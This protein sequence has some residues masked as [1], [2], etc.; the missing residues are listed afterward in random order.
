EGCALF[1]QICHW[2][3]S[4]LVAL[5]STRTRRDSLTSRDNAMARLSFACITTSEARYSLP[6]A[7]RNEAQSNDHFVK[8]CGIRAAPRDRLPAARAGGFRCFAEPRYSQQALRRPAESPGKPGVSGY[9][10]GQRRACRG[11]ARRLRR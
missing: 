3:I 10:A 4:R 5:R 2:I 6:Q 8:H 1:T 9:A 11:A 7:W